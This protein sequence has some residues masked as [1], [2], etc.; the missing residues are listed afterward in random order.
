MST[1][2]RLA[3]A[4]LLVLAS[5]SGPRPQEEAA[6]SPDD[7]AP[8]ESAAPQY[9][10]LLFDEEGLVR[11]D[12]PHGERRVQIAGA[13]PAGLVSPSPNGEALALTFQREDS[14]FLARIDLESDDLAI[15]HASGRDAVYTAAWGPDSSRFAFGYRSSGGGDVLISTAGGLDD[16]GCSASTLAAHWPASERL[17]TGAETERYVVSASDCAT[18]ATVDA[19]KMHHVRYA[20]GRARMAYVFRDLVYD[21]PSRSYVPDST[22]FVADLDGSNAEKLFGDEYDARHPSWS[23]DGSTLA[24]DVR[25]Q[26]APHRRRIVLRDASDLT[27]LVAPA[28][29]SEADI[30]R[31]VWSPEGRQV[32]FDLVADGR[33]SKAVR[34]FGRTKVFDVEAD[35]TWGWIDEET[36]AFVTRDDS[37][38]AVSLDGDLRFS[39]G[40]GAVLVHAERVGGSDTALA[41]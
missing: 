12:R 35:S 40:P 34:S 30:V 19:R 32:A 11:V 2:T 1:S 15:V 14:T 25:L 36:L 29:F 23:P 24:F 41:R 22:L 28:D 17:V 21:R 4:A 18:L 8:T 13:R 5:C 10:L 20:P 16:P 39:L 33:I 3:L 38:K 37:V 9:S 27:Y 31:P 6:E 26:E 7:P